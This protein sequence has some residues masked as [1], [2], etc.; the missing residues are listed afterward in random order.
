MPL[1]AIQ[2]VVVDSTDPTTTRPNIPPVEK[3]GSG[4][5]PIDLPPFSSTINLPPHI[6]PIDAW[7]LFLLFFPIE[8]IQVICDNTNARKDRE[9]QAR[10]ESDNLPAHA[11]IND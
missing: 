4:F 11:R 10:I 2:Q 6:K 9:F 7:G 1:K 5:I 3:T 8:Q